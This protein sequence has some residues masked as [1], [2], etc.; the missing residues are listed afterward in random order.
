MWKMIQQGG[1][2][3]YAALYDHE[4]TDIGS[5]PDGS[6][7]LDPIHVTGKANLVELRKVAQDNGLTVCCKALDIL[8]SHSAFVQ[9]VLKTT[10]S[11]SFKVDR[12]RKTRRVTSSSGGSTFANLI[13]GR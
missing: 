5:Y 10:S 12:H 7:Y 1:W 4:A 2:K 13:S 8:E 9:E 3:K 11:A 6:Q